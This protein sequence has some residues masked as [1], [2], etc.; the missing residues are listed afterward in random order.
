M[1]WWCGKL[2]EHQRWTHPWSLLLRGLPQWRQLRVE[3][4][5]IMTIIDTISREL[6]TCQALCFPPLTLRKTPWS[7]KLLSRPCCCVQE[8]T[9]TQEVMWLAQS[10]VS[11]EW[12]KPGF[13]IHVV[14]L[15]SCH[16]PIEYLLRGEGGQIWR[17]LQNGCLFSFLIPVIG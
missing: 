9:E 5:W 6:T 13:I 11:R 14:W 12:H 1:E 16:W 10:P 7:A 3:G 17:C 4:D 8:E 15:Q 2:W